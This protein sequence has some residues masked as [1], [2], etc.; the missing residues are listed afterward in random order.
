LAFSAESSQ[1]ES[2]GFCV[3]DLLLYTANAWQ[4]DLQNGCLGQLTEVYDD[5][6]QVNV[7]TVD[8][9]IVRGAL[10]CAIYEGIHH[11]VLET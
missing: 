10:G 7:G 9:P 11:Y 8:H 1:V 5:V 2:T 6:V 3:G 4:R